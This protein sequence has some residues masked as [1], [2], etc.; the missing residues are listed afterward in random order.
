MKFLI[1]IIF[2]FV[3]NINHVLSDNLYDALKIAYKNNKELN[4]E[5]ENVNIAEQDLKISKGNYLPSG[6]ITGSKSQQDT[7]K[8][9]NQS[10]GDAATNDVNPLNTTIKI[11]QTLIDFGRNA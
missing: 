4:A 1:A 2:I 11:E 3:L 5:R 6:T 7:N 8:L 10:G 9:T